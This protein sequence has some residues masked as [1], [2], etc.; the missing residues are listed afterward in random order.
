MNDVTQILSRVESGDVTAA[1]QLLP[2]V[3]DELRKVAAHQLRREKPG[4]TLQATALVHEAYLKLVDGDQPQPWNGRRHFFAAAAQAMHRILVDRA[5]E[6]LS[7]K[8]GGQIDRQDFDPKQLAATAPPSEIVAV[9]DALDALAAHDPSAVELVKLHY[10]AG[11]SLEETAEI[12][13][14]SRA[15]AYR[16]WTYARAWLRASLEEKR[17]GE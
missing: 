10:F 2:L 9:H 17:A 8:G 12:L 5:R 15:T 3:Y 4:Q 14:I 1:G 13:Q 7:I 11:F 16:L 6:K